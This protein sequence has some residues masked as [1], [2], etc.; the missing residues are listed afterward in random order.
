[1]CQNPSQNCSQNVVQQISEQLSFETKKYFLR[2]MSCLWDQSM[3][4]KSTNPEFVL[5]LVTNWGSGKYLY[6]NPLAE[7][8]QGNIQIC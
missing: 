5:D 3:K 4:S 2:F 8:G 6:Q 1:M 7:S